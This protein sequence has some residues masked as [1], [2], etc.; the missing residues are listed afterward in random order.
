MREQDRHRWV[1][2]EVDPSG[3]HFKLH[4]TGPNTSDKLDK[5]VTP[6]ALIGKGEGTTLVVEFLTEAPGLDNAKDALIRQLDF[7]ITEHTDEDKWAYLIYHATRTAANLY[8]DA[9]WRY[10]PAS[11]RTE[12]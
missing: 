1:E 12:G 4:Y 2:G 6:L 8:A 7:F 10:F 5:D 11:G 3:E 9:L